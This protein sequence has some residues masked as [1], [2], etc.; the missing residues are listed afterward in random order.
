MSNAIIFVGL[1]STGLKVIKETESA[2]YENNGKSFPDNIGAIFLETDNNSDGGY[3][4]DGSK[5][6][7][8]PIHIDLG[9]KEQTIIN[10][11]SDTTFTYPWL[12]DAEL[13]YYSGDGAGGMPTFGRLGFY[14]R[15][16]SQS[17]LE[18]FQSLYSKISP[19]T[20]GLIVYIVGSFTGG[21]GSGLLI[22]TANFIRNQINNSN[23]NAVH[24]IGLLPKNS[25][26]AEDDVFALNTLTGLGTLT[27]YSVNGLN[28]EFKYPNTGSVTKLT[29]KPYDT[30]ALLSLEYNDSK[31]LGSLNALIKNAANMLFIKTIGSDQEIVNNMESAVSA[32]LIDT[33]SNGWFDTFYTAGFKYIQYPKSKILTVLYS[34]LL[35]EEL[36]NLVDQEKYYQIPKDGGATTPKL[37][38]DAKPIIREQVNQFI[39]DLL[40]G[41]LEISYTWNGKNG[42]VKNSLHRESR[43]LLNSKS[44]LP[45]SRTV[46]EMF[47]ADVESSFYNIAVN[48]TRRLKEYIIT[49]VNDFLIGKI[50]KLYGSFTVVD[51]ALKYLT[52]QLEQVQAWNSKIFK[53]E[54]NNNEGWKVTLREK[55]RVLFGANADKMF[56]GKSEWLDN[57]FEE[58]WKLTVFHVSIGLFP[59]LINTLSNNAVNYNDEFI[60]SDNFIWNRRKVVAI[61]DFINQLVNGEGNN[62]APTLRSRRSEIINS[63]QLENPSLVYLYLEGSL[64]ADA[65]NLKK[66]YYNNFGNNL[67]RLTDFM[68]LD[69]LPY[70]LLEN[71]NKPTVLNQLLGN[72]SSHFKPKIGSLI[73]TNIYD[74]IKN[75]G[76]GQNQPNNSVRSWY[77]L[78]EKVDP[79]STQQL[80]SPMI[81][82]SSGHTN[83]S[84]IPSRMK[85][86]VIGSNKNLVEELINIDDQTKIL[87]IPEIEESICFYIDYS[88][89]GGDNTISENFKTLKP[90]RHLLLS[91]YAKSVYK[92]KLS[93]GEFKPNK[94]LAYLTIE[95]LN[96]LVNA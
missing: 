52:A 90:V 11:R 91:E 82:L 72:I 19:G 13:L 42:D 20:N 67:Y 58:L 78:F 6:K 38:G 92:R 63:V 34:D 56:N 36:N 14:D 61:V 57:C 44:E 33:I 75:K 32:S 64:N 47:E 79:K 17:F 3:L 41:I 94:S 4:P 60:T 16:T 23:L 49:Q 18:S 93:N 53:S 95:E 96:E 15:G 77:K 1:G 43:I 10:L 27:H 35:S 71:A 69:K 81:K 45:L 40:N 39:D 9:N 22:D 85:R 54:T 86:Y 62:N 59:K 87:E 65:D 7:I 73:K 37:I 28:S 30:Y 21:T 5:S 66:D 88:Y 50:F 74:I 51:F 24:G 55:T 31:E 29:Q 80:L 26:L 68:G 84:V 46:I 76:Q 25:M 83:F 8:I 2:Y 48:N 70:F 89:V 12:P